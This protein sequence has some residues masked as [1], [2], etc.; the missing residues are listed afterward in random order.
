[1]SLSRLDIL[2]LL[3]CRAAE[4]Q[5]SKRVTKARLKQSKQK[6]QVMKAL[7]QYMTFHGKTL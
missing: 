1:M 6:F 2:S 4:E 5:I 7:K 3:F